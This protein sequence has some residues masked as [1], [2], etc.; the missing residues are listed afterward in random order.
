VRKDG[1][2]RIAI[3]GDFSGRPPGRRPPGL[4]G[5]R[6]IAA[7]RD[8]FDAVMAKVRPELRLPVGSDTVAI[9]FEELESFHPDS[10][11]E[12]LDVFAAFRQARRRLLDPATF[13]EAV[14][15]LGILPPREEPIEA[16]ERPALKTG[17]SLL[18]QIAN[19]SSPVSE[20][21]PAAPAREDAWKRV[22]RG[23]VA[24][25]IIPRADP[26]QADV[27]AELDASAGETMRAILHHP[28]FQALEAAWRTLFW[29]L[30]RLETGEDLRLYIVDAAWEDVIADL[31]RAREPA[32][33]QLY[34]LLVDEGPWTV[35]AGLYAFAPTVGDAAVLER[36]GAL[37]ARGGAGFL[38]AASPRFAGAL[39]RDEEKAWNTLRSSPA[40]QAIGLVWPR[41]LL[42]LPYGGKT[43]STDLFEFEEMP[44]QE[45]E[46]YLWGNPAAAAVCLLGESYAQGGWDYT[47]GL[48]TEIGGLPVHTWRD[49]DGE[50]HMQPC[51]EC[52]LTEGEAAR[53]LDRGIMPLVAL[54]GRDAVR[55]FR[56]QSIAA[57][58][59][60]LRGTWR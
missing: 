21:A 4:E 3:L 14:R 50:A 54:K 48:N 43:L 37:S 15:N 56:F 8:D 10:L 19:A 36:M 16:A 2:F 22:I 60:P 41:F 58:P 52:W 46:A 39:T 24:P 45:H 42:R 31:L 6:A 26:R 49:E 28:D 55:L 12:R 30:S 34:R 17:A 35:V 5:R 51:A 53:L 33:S 44:E 13:T 23:I 57:P 7:D 20:R 9:R 47:P 1:P 59:T 11:W 25:H 32:C 29:L 40:A 38:G 27:V 18:E